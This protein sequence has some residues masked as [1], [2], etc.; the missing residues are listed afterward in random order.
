MHPIFTVQRVQGVHC[1]GHLN[2]HSVHDDGGIITPDRR[3]GIDLRALE[4][5]S[6]SHR[7]SIRHAA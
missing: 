7:E 4:P 3:A 1:G 2:L 6:G 5:E